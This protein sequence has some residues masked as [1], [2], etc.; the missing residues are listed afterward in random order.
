MSHLVIAHKFDFDR[1]TTLNDTYQRIM[2]INFF[3][4]KVDVLQCPLCD[5][6]FSTVEMAADHFIEMDH[7]TLLVLSDQGCLIP[8]LQ[9]DLLLQ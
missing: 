7:G 6:M 8:F 4:R 1:I 5:N 3:R 2:Q 9:D